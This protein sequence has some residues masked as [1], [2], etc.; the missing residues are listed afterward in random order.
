MLERSLIRFS[1]DIGSGDTCCPAPILLGGEGISFFFSDSGSKSLTFK[2]CNFN[3]ADFQSIVPASITLNSGFA[4]QFFGDQSIEGMHFDKHAVELIEIGDQCFRIK[5]VES[6]ATS[7]FEDSYFI[8]TSDIDDA[9]VVVNDVVLLHRINVGQSHA[10]KEVTLTVDYRGGDTSGYVPIIAD[11]EGNET[12]SSSYGAYGRTTG[13]IRVN[14]GQDGYGTYKIVFKNTTKKIIKEDLS[15]P[16]Y[17]GV[18]QMDVPNVTIKEDDTIYYSNA[19]YIAGNVDDE[20]ISVLKY[21]CDENAFGFPFASAGNSAYVRSCLPVII[22]RPQ[23]KQSDKT[24]EKLDGESVVLFATIGKEYELQTE[25]IPEHWHEVIITALSC[26][27]LFI[28]GIH[29]S[30]SSEYSIDWDKVAYDDCGHKLVRA[31]CKVQEQF[32]VRN[33]N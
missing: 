6:G 8:E 29:V 30:K 21:R 25:Y 28:N 7:S 33:S 23:F 9:E 12:E 17:F 11:F 31:T 32:N 27:K 4:G 15:F 24:Y 18:V 22:S 5:A 13:D 3:G 16:Y 14:V 20:D 10:G 2:L 1:T 26:D 19:L